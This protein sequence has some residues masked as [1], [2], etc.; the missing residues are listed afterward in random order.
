[1]YSNIY[2]QDLA[3]AVQEISD[4]FEALKEAELQALVERVRIYPDGFEFY[5]RSTD[6]TLEKSSVMSAT[7]SGFAIDD[8]QVWY[9][10][11]VPSWTPEAD[12]FMPLSES[13]IGRAI[14]K[15]GIPT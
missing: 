1:M 12:E 15:F 8:I 2:P 9:R 11:N 7:I 4:R 3:S 6:E 5:Y 14:A 13:A 10:C